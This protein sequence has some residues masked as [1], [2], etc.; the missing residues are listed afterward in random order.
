MARNYL[1][2]AGQ[3]VTPFTIMTAFVKDGPLYV[4]EFDT[5]KDTAS[6]NNDEGPL[7]PF[8]RRIEANGG[9][10][11]T[12]QTLLT[13]LQ[14]LFLNDMGLGGRGYTIDDVQWLRPAN[15]LTAQ[16]VK[17]NDADRKS[18]LLQGTSYNTYSST[19]SRCSLY[20]RIS[21]P[22]KGS[23]SSRVAARGTM[24][25]WCRSRRS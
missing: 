22:L 3:V 24:L 8:H 7:V 20:C 19:P 17:D 6:F 10:V 23:Q 4:L 25:P 14:T 1:N 21:Y 2:Y 15:T 9:F 5:W 16:A 18:S 13:N 12:N 11:T